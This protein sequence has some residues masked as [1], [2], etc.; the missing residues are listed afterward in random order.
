MS[1]EFV[2]DFHRFFSVLLAE[3]KKTVGIVFCFLLVYTQNTKINCMIGTFSMPL[4]EEVMEGDILLFFFFNFTSCQL[5][6]FFMVKI[7]DN[8]NQHF[9]Q[10]VT[11]I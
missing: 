1:N 2:K 5:N 8:A 7:L 4:S 10:F 11:V 3:P 9:E 6:Q